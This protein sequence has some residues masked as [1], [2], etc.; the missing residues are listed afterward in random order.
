MLSIVLSNLLENAYKYSATD[1]P[2]LVTLAPH[3]TEDGQP[4][5]RWTVENTVGEA[6]L[7]DAAQVFDKYYRSPHAQRQSGSGLGLFLVKS[8]V[9]L[10]RGRVNCIPLDDRVRFE[11]WLPCDGYAS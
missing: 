3:T 5:W 10:M 2:I 7:P 6:G 9:E 4:S 8:L 1:T 11:W